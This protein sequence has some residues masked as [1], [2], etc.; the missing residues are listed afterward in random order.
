MNVGIRSHRPISIDLFQRN[1][2][3]GLTL[4][5]FRVAQ[6]VI[7]L[8]RL[9]AEAPEFRGLLGILLAADD[10]ILF[11]QHRHATGFLARPARSGFE[12]TLVLLPRLAVGD[13]PIS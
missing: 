10:R 2:A 3:V 5:L 13:Q 12:F 8:K 7:L 6:V 4:N 11:Y 1:L 9:G